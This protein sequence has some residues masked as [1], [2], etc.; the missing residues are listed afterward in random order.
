MSTI[1]KFSKAQISDLIQSRGFLCSRLGKLRKKV[2]TDLA[3]PFAKINLPGLVKNLAS[4]IALK[5]INKFEKAISSKGAVR[6]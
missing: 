3:T 1:K 6:T 5:A 2:V 4:N